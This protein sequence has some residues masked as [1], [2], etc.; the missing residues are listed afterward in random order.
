MADLNKLIMD[1]HDSGYFSMMSRNPLAQFGGP[2][3]NYIG[4]QF[5]PEMMVEENSFREDQIKFRT[6]VANAGTRYSPTQKKEGDLY[7]YFDVI[8][9]ES[10]I[11]RE[12][13]GRQYDTLLKLVNSDLSMDAM[14]SL[15]NW[16]EV[17]LNRALIDRAE[18]DRWEVIVN[19]EV[20]RTGDNGYTENVTYPDPVGQRVNASAAW[21][22]DATD[23]FEDI[24]AR[25]DFMADKGF[26][27]NRII[28]SR[29]VAT[30][31]ANNA[32]VRSR[33]SRLQIDTGGQLSA[34]PGR[35]TMP[36]I[37]SALQADGLPPIEMYDL[38]YRTQTGNP[39]FVPDDV[40]VMICTTGRDQSIMLPETDEQIPM[41]DTLGYYA[42][43]RAAGQSMPGKVIRLEPK[44][45]KPPRILGEAWMTSLPVL[46]EPEAIA[47]I[48]NIT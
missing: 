42:I 1:A 28:C 37:N 21:S 43:G 29:A 14:A 25:A 32:I 13:T 31:L 11:A 23:P 26:E 39:R 38:R 36:A 20:T 7:G 47:V 35:S 16:V 46:L 17:T 5:F 4:A 27:I 18:A 33:T 9:A 40:F 34:S 19:A 15:I 44:E 10:D 30:K 48:K 3:R 8:L 6:V 12:L 45:D 24:F 2:A 41:T 22:N